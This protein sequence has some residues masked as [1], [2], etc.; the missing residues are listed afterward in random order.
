MVNRR[1]KSGRGDRFYFLGLQNHCGRW[2]QPWRH[3]LLKRKAMTNLDRVLKSKYITLLTV[4]HTKLW[5]ISPVM[6]LSSFSMM[7]IERTFPHRLKVLSWEQ[8]LRTGRMDSSWDSVIPHC[9]KFS[10][11]RVAATC[12]RRMQRILGLKSVMVTPLRSRPLSWWMFGHWDR[13]VRS[14]S[15]SWQLVIARWSKGVI[16]HLGR[17]KSDEVWETQGAAVLGRWLAQRQGPTVSWRSVL[18]MISLLFNLTFHLCITWKPPVVCMFSGHTSLPS[19]QNRA[20][21]KYLPTYLEKATF[22]DW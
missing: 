14:N 17:K 5:L 22:R 11:W 6:W 2:L 20:F 4:I 19:S 1:A 8:Q 18:R 10:S 16:R 7:A 12:S 15:V 13:W 9:S 3:L 21:L